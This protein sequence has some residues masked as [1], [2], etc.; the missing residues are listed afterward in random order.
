MFFRKNIIKTLKHKFRKFGIP[1]ILSRHQLFT[2]QRSYKQQSYKQQYKQQYKQPT[3]QPNQLLK[4]MI[5]AGSLGFGSDLICQSLVEKKDYYDYMRLGSLTVFSMLYIG[6]FLHYLYKAYPL[7]VTRIPFGSLR[8]PSSF[9]HSLVCSLIDNFHCGL[10]YIPAY[11]LFMDLSSTNKTYQ[12]SIHHL[13]SEWLT[14]YS[15]CTLFW[16]PFMCGN[17][18]FVPPI[19][20]VSAMAIANLGWS[21]GIDYLAHRN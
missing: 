8:N 20:R 17:F 2:Y 10:I 14:A 1:R 7:L 6:G 3:E 9:G 5:F 19:Y 4:N 11:F 15:T 13:Q 18:F 12:Q 16:V 21:I